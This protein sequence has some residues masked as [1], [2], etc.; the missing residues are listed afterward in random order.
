MKIPTLHAWMAPVLLAAGLSSTTTA[1]SDPVPAGMLRYPDVSQNHIVFSY[2]ND[3]WLVSRKGGVAT[4]LASPDGQERFP[5]FSADGN[6]IAFVGNYDGNT[7]IYTIPTVGGV[8]ERVTYHPGSETLC[9]WLPSNEL[10]FYARGRTGIGAQSKV[11]TVKPTGAMVKELPIPYGTVS[12][13]S[14]DGKWLAYTPNTRDSRTWKRYQGGLATDI[15]L[16]NLED[17]SAKKITDWAGTDTQ[18]MWWGNTLYYLSDA[19]EDHRL[20]IWKYSLRTE[21]H[22]QVT[23]Y[24][25]NDIKWPAVG[26]GFKDQ[27][28]I[29]YQ[30]GSDLMLFNLKMN[31]DSKV[32]VFIP[33]EAP[34]VRAKNVDA[35]KFIQDWGVSPTGKRAVVSARGDIWTLPSEKGI[36][37]NLTSSQTVAERSPEWS[38]DGRWIAYFSDSTGE[39]ELWITQ[40]DGKGETKQL[41]SDGGLFKE[42][43][44]WSPDSK[45]IAYLDCGGNLYVHNIDSGE[46]KL[47]DESRYGFWI[48]SIGGLSWS[49]DGRL[50]TYAKVS[51]NSSQTAVWIL[52]TEDGSKRQVTSGFFAD[53]SP[54]FDR[55]G[56]YLYYTSGR[57]FSPSYSSVDMTYIYEDSTVLMAVPLQAESDRLWAPENDEEEWEEEKEDGE[58]KE[59]GDAK[60]GDEADEADEGKDEN[61]EEGEG[62]G[63]EQAAPSDA[64]TGTWEGTLNGPDIP[65]DGVPITINLKLASDGSVS[66]GMVTPLGTANIDSGSFDEASGKLTMELTADVGFTLSV[67]AKVDGESMSGTGTAPDQGITF[68]FE[69][70]R[71]SS[72]S[73]SDNGDGEGDDEE[74]AE[75]V[76]IDYEGFEAR[77]IQLPVAPGRLGNLQVNNK[78][79]L[80]YGRFG[81]NGGI[82]LFDLEDDGKSEKSVGSGGGFTLTADGKKLMTRRGSS[83]Y[84]QA[85]SAGGS[86]KSVPTKGMT[87]RINPKEEWGQLFTDAW[88]IFRDYFYDPN[89]HGVDW[90]WVHDHYKA[91]IVHCASREDLTF[92]IGE[93]ISEVNVGHAYIGGHGDASPRAKSVGIGMLGVDWELHEGAYRIANIVRGADWDSDGRGPLSMPGVDVNQGDY[94]LAV[95]GVPMDAS[96]SPYAAFQGLSG[97]E[98]LLTVSTKPTMDDEAREVLVKTISSERSLRYRAWI[99]RNRKYVEEKSGGKLGYIYVPNTGIAGQ[100]DL[101]RQFFGQTLKQGL[102]IDERWNGGGQI[103]NRFVELL[104]RP[105]SNYWATRG[106]QDIHWPPD[107]HQGP[108]CMLINENAGSGGDAF[109]AY[110]RQAGLG[111]LIGK[112]TW[113]GLVGISGNPTLIDGGSLTV[114]TFGFYSREGEW[115]IEGY[116]VDPDIEVVDDPSLMVDGGDP[117]LDAAIEHMMGEV[118]RIPFNQPGRPTYPDRSGIGIDPAHK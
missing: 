16:F 80:L 25:D 38:P 97:K 110:F 70:S 22:E 103:P 115:S 7:D 93:M 69:A 15:W 56:K 40:S 114:P 35:S 111:K 81:Q 78:G 41:T 29:V 87:V 24:K 37:R 2:A 101:Y 21:K 106:K 39:Y 20:N 14:A 117:Q 6:S 18:P 53:G 83:A 88:R 23:F 9:D 84:I 46:S 73:S 82:K 1:Q 75:K 100:N 45:Q 61:G 28:E 54:T 63:G 4:P 86:G 36:A 71:A 13:I 11:C 104:N 118:E 109:P 60:D 55:K 49:H 19:G 72:G 89:L 66:G 85:A 105:V 57:N 59:D 34:H 51:Q 64:L 112:R 8:A 27:G 74:A 50:L 47:M 108:K 32:E 33:G 107:S 42:S 79:Q 67:E 58:D 10:L 98:I 76:E 95:N 31:R 12:S 90:Q 48:G 44:Y 26:P 96:K 92:L 102:I 116:G 65:E 3:L 94:V 62:D 52:N 43:I 113:G 77:A 99:E 17:H 68:K 91:M 5:R 30:L